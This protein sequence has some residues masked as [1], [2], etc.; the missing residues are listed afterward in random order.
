MTIIILDTEGLLS[1]EEFGSIFDNQMITMAVLS[2]HIVLINH[3]GELSASLEGLIGMS[4]YAKLHLQ[5]SPLKPKVMFVLRDQMDRGQEVFVEQLTKLRNNL[6]KSSSFLRV[7]IDNE[8]EIREEHLALLPCAFSED[9]NVD[10]NLTQRWRNQTFPSEIMKLRSQ[11]FQALDEHKITPNFS[12]KNFDYFSKKICVNWSSIDQLGQGLLECKTLYELS[13]INELK[14]IAKTIVTKKSE[15]QRNGGAM[16]KELLESRDNQTQINLDIYMRDLIKKGIQQLDNLTSDLVHEANNEFESSTQQ[17]YFAELRPKV[18]QNIEPSIRCNQ[19]VLQAQFEEDI[20]TVARV[21]A[22]MQVQKQLL[23]SAKTFFDRKSRT[24]D[25]VE[26]LNQALEFKHKELKSEFEQS[27]NLLRKSH[28]AIIKTIHDNYNQIVRSRR[29]NTKTDDIYNRCP[30]FDSHSYLERCKQL[31]NIFG[32]NF[33]FFS[34]KQ[35]D[36]SFLHRLRERFISTENK[37][38]DELKWFRDHRDYDRNRE[39]FQQINEELM[40]NLH[41]NI[42]KMLANIRLVYSDPQTIANSIDYVDNAVN[43]TQSC[44]QK[45]YKHIKEGGHFVHKTALNEN[46]FKNQF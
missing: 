16:L 20:Y 18:K 39:I 17:S 3:K 21:S 5:T 36:P 31:D 22:T 41:K 15:L 43:G 6:H 29:A 24:T 38:L 37:V 1:L 8:L 46:Q 42:V 26:E 12:F 7:S 34:T 28:E 33:K 45:Y 4:L 11:I 10:L 35:K 19:Q 9:T 40:P 44:I 32:L 14:E 27:Q 2:S 25:D 23:E 13:V 30:S